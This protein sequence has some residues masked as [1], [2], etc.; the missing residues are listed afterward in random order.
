MSEQAY[1]SY[2]DLEPKGAYTGVFAALTNWLGAIVSVFLVIGL[3]S[4]GYRLTMRDVTDVPVVRAMEGPLR[5]QPLDPGG[6]IAAHQGLAVNTVQSDG[7]AEAPAERVVLAPEP[8][9][10]LDEDLALADLDPAP[11]NLTDVSAGIQATEPVPSLNELITS[12]IQGDQNART[13][14]L[15]KLPGVKRSPRPRARAIVAALNA[16][17]ATPAQRSATAIDVDPAAVLTGTRLV[18]LGA[19]DD[20]GAAILE[21]DHIVE[22]HGDLIGSRQRLIQKAESGGRSF[23]RLRMVGFENLSDSRRLCSALLARGTP[24][25]PVTAR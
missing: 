4:W 17:D 18:Q 14:A 15:A 21:W 16:P 1:L 24:C 5:V 23:Y 13:A 25:I 12:T 2:R 11:K 19:F 22:R 3:V 7:S 10:L 8:V 9:D 20:R 6:E